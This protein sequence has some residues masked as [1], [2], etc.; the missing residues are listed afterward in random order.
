MYRP[1]IRSGGT[2]SAVEG[3]QRAF[4]AG[5]GVGSETF[6]GSKIL[7]VFPFGKAFRLNTRFKRKVLATQKLATKRIRRR[8]RRH[9]YR[10][11]LRGDSRRADVRVSLTQ[12]LQG[13]EREM[14]EAAL[15]ESRGTVAGANGATATLGI[16]P[17][18]L[19]SKIKQLIIATHEFT[20]AS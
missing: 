19:A 14:V 20:A 2:T 11:D 6:A 15:G 13:Q 16:P 8:W 10:Q 1:S 17:S 18:T 5:P 9:S 4:Q 12:T 7:K 3:G